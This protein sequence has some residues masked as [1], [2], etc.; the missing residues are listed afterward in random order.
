MHAVA[1]TRER[2]APTM[3]PTMS[4][5]EE[6]LDFEAELRVDAEEDPLG[7]GRVSGLELKMELELEPAIGRVLAARVVGDISALAEALPAEAFPAE[8][9]EAGAM[10]GAVFSVDPGGFG[11]GDT[12]EEWI[13]VPA[14]EA[15]VVGD[16]VVVA[17]C[18]GYLL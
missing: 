6:C 13:G 9:G 14:G 12:V 2:M 5:V 15:S 7:R 10:V 4:P 18:C 16:T 3:A 11:S 17:G 1:S 8:E